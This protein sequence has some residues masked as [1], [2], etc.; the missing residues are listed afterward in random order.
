[1]TILRRRFCVEKPKREVLTRLALLVITVKRP[2][3]RFVPLNLLCKHSY[4]SG[5]GTRC[6]AAGLHAPK[7][8]VTAAT[9]LPHRQID[10]LRRAGITDITL[11]LSTASKISSRSG[12]PDA[13]SLSYT[14]SRA[15]GTAGPTVRRDLIA[16]DRRLNG[17]I[18][19]DL[20]LKRHPRAR[21][22]AAVATIVPRPRNRPPTASR[23]EEDGR[24]DASSKAEGRGDSR[25][26]H[27]RRHLRP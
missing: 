23:D 24:S 16:S 14:A 25:Q 5:K 13:A 3:F 9:P 7:S 10:T 21:R 27:Q 15:D 12:R 26:H 18:V 6:A 22:A 19:T 1:M 20:D 8:I 11:S 17:D 4:R 2:R